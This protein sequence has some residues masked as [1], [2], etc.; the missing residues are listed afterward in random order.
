M[1]R[2]A[3][4]LPEPLQTCPVIQQ[5]IVLWMKPVYTVFAEW[6]I[7]GHPQVEDQRSQQLEGIVELGAPLQAVREIL[8]AH[9]SSHSHMPRT[10]RRRTGI[11]V[12]SRSKAVCSLYFFNSN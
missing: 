1:E 8:E 9:S 7:L 3:R 6:I 10:R 2:V 12:W 4:G 5:S 11:C